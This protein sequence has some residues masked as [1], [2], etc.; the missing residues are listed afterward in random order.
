LLLVDGKLA[1]FA[2]VDKEVV[3][4]RSQRSLTKFF[5]LRKY[6]RQGIGRRAAARIF[7]LL[8]GH[9]EVRV[10]AANTPAQA[11]WRALSNTISKGKYREIAFGNDEWRWPVFAVPVGKAT[12]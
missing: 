1:G 12:A 8:P 2:L 11:F 4:E 7:K 10:I 5:L 9:W 3:I 6:R